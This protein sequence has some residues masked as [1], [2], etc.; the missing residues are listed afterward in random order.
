MRKAAD[1]VLIAEAKYNKRTA[2]AIAME[3]TKITGKVE[4]IHSDTGSKSEGIRCFVKDISGKRY[5]L[6]RADILPQYDDLLQSFEG[7]TADITGI[8]E[9][10][11]GNFRVTDITEHTS[12]KSGNNSDTDTREEEIT[13]EKTDTQEENIQEDGNSSTEEDSQK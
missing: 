11:T 1:S 10:R 3:T 5:K 13:A 4:C 12:E 6:Y 2:K 9:E 7:K 8:P